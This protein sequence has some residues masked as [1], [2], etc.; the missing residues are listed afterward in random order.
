MLIVDDAPEVRALVRTTLRRSGDLDVVGEAADGH[1]AVTLAG[2][3]RPSLVLLDASM[4]GCDGL[5]A[6]PAILQV[7]PA[8]KVVLY[9]GFEEQGLAEKAAALG[10]ADFVAKSVPLETLADR[11]RAVLDDGEGR[12]DPPPAEHLLHEHLERFREVFDQAAIG[13]ATTTL[14]GRLVRA[15]AALGRVLGRSPDG[16][17][18]TSYVDLATDRRRELQTAVTDL[19]ERRRDVAELEH[20]VDR[21]G[22]S[23]WVRTTLAPVRDSA[24]RPL[25][26]FLQAQDVTAERASAEALRR[27]EQRFRLLVEAVQ[28][29]AIFMLDPQG[30]I[31]S[32]NSG[33]ER[34]KGYTADEII[35]RHFSVFYPPDVAA[36][37][38]PER[39]LE[40]ALRDGQYEEEGWRL[41]KDGTR[42]WANVLI[43]AI[44]DPAGKH[45]GFTKVTR[46]TTE[47]RRLE[48]ELRRAAEDQ[49]RFLAVTAHELRTPVGVLAGS[50]EL[51][52][53]HWAEMTADERT[54][55]LSAMD[56]STTRLRRLLDD[57][58]TASRLQASAMDVSPAPVLLARSVAEA[59]AR[60]NGP[61][62]G[63]IGSE[64][65]RGLTVRADPDRLAQMLD[66]L[67]Q[68]AL[69]HG[70][71]PVEVTAEAQGEDVLLRVAD[72]GPGV[73]PEVRSRLFDRFASARTGSDA[74]K[75]GTGLGLYIVREL[76]RAHGGD[77]W[78]DAPDRARPAGAF[79]LRLP[80]AG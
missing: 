35:G 18:G 14:A 59:V 10:A 41:R 60:L 7:S 49:A 37:G 76:A 4:P 68:N 1:E 74:S 70:A 36:S 5:E 69:R 20:R 12:K 72:H 33:A 58:L 53:R 34:S 80:R 17:V 57:L 15:N 64:V 27:S 32:W 63:E 23:R 67:L 52:S 9:T 13:M 30:H 8:T 55:L 19:A 6:L 43:T 44:F 62:S 48:Q 77:A 39:E 46:D 21:A 56:G 28:D 25:Y 24:G 79:V 61:G 22:E 51:L 38:H 71:A 2:R 75:G 65:P 40:L 3:L 78:Y 47:R 29:Y 45:V 50:A 16:L 66:N 31:V 54:D 26:L 11:L 42:F 73:P